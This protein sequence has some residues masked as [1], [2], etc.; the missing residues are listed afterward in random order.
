M[1]ANFLASRTAAKLARKEA[2][3]TEI[4]AFIAKHPATRGEIMARLSSGHSAE[5]VAR[6]LKNAERVAPARTSSKFYR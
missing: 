1:I 6:S 3:A 5:S 2:A 4:K